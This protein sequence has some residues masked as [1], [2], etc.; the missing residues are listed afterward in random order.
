MFQQG[1]QR[2]AI[3]LG[4]ANHQRADGLVGNAELPG[5]PSIHVCAANIVVCFFCSGFR[6]KASMNDAAV[7]F[8]CAVRNVLEGFQYGDFPAVSG[9][10]LRKGAANYARAN[11]NN[12]I[13]GF[14][15]FM[16]QAVQP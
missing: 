4:K 15:S 1:I 3:F 2:G 12:I 5:Q 14:L 8:A 11:D 10:L 6:I 9:Q 16:V 13:H 7:C